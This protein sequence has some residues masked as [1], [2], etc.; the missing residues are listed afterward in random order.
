MK[1]EYNVDK[2]RLLKSYKSLLQKKKNSDENQEE[3]NFLLIDKNEDIDS[4]PYGYQTDTV[5]VIIRS[6]FR[7]L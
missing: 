7:I 5:R 3:S 1:D 4:C 2:S 6:I